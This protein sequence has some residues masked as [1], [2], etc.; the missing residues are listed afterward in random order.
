M[1]GWIKPEFAQ[2]DFGPGHKST[3]VVASG[4]Q[5]VKN[6][7]VTISAGE[8]SLADAGVITSEELCAAGVSSATKNAGD[9]LAVAFG[10]DVSLE[11]AF[12][13]SAGDFVKVYSEGK[14]GPALVSSDSFAVRTQV[15]GSDFGNQPTNDGIEVVSSSASDTQYLDLY[16]TTHGGVVVVKERIQLTG[17][18]PVSTTKVDW[19]RLLGAIIP[20]GL[21]A[22]AVGT[23][24][25]REASGNA[26]ITTITAGQ[27]SSGVEYPDTDMEA[28]F[29]H[30][31]SFSSDLTTDK[32]V[33]VVGVGAD[34]S[35][36]VMEAVTLADT[37]QI[38]TATA[39]SEITYL[40]VGDFESANILTQ[41]LSPFSD[42]LSIVGIAKEAG[43]AG[44]VVEISFK[45]REVTKKDEDLGDL[46]YVSGQV[47]AA[48][49]IAC[50]TTPIELLP[51]PPSGFSYEMES[52]KLF[53]DYGSVA[54]TLGSM[55]TITLKI[56]TQGPF[57]AFLP[58][59]ILS[60][61]ADASL[62]VKAVSSS[63]ENGRVT[64]T[65]NA[66]ATSGGTGSVLRW[67]AWFRVSPISL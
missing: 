36:V 66:D 29:A 39:L 13:V 26:T 62:I 5:I 56:G 20:L 30:P 60:G 55:A 28:A 3:V 54:V 2:D 19:G 40:L 43:D 51:A 15:S 67:E 23:I 45:P 24:T 1:G 38:M 22:A 64:I 6:R 31:V 17:T 4:S 33:G 52:M 57:V 47:A 18:T 14:V 9:E 12:P 58:V 44:D 46:H 10:G 63:L 8:A 41:R 25:I 34:G 50:F 7:V 37:A 27:R 16:G 42:N 11:L 35:T 61:T 53:W 59:T 21:G 32:V 48:D 49:L 65:A